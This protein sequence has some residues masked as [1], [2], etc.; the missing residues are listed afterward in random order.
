MS[1][2][3]AGRV[4]VEKK[5]FLSYLEK[6]TVETRVSTS[7]EKKVLSGDGNKGQLTFS[8]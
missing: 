6:K 1:V 2:G 3:D 8:C 7:V 4:L 5:V